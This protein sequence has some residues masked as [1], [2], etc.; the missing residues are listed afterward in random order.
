MGLT[1]NPPCSRQSARFLSRPHGSIMAAAMGALHMNPVDPHVNAQAAD[2]AIVP[3]QVLQGAL[4]WIRSEAMRLLCRR[5]VKLCTHCQ[6]QKL[7]ATAWI[8]CIATLRHKKTSGS[9]IAEMALVSLSSHK[10]PDSRTGSRDTKHP[11]FR[12]CRVPVCRHIQGDDL[13]LDLPRTGS[14]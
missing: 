7:L 8:F 1:R 3:R 14:P 4:P 11:E 12:R 13:W 5:V 10:L 9:K 6:G 2:A